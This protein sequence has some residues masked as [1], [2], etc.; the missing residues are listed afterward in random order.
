MRQATDPGLSENGGP[1]GAIL[2]WIPVPIWDKRVRLLTV[3]A[4]AC[5]LSWP[6]RQATITEKPKDVKK[7]LTHRFL[8]LRGKAFTWHLS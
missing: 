4:A 6:M 7:V 2:M 3:V 8:Q 5:S 1:T